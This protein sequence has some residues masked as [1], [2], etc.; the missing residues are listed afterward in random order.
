VV[1]C[2]VACRISLALRVPLDEYGWYPPPLIAAFGATA[3]VGR[4]LKLD[5]TQMIDAFSLTLNQTTCSAELKFSPHSHIRAVRDAFPAQI[6][7]TSALLARKG[8]RGF[9]HPFE[10]RA[11]FFALFARGEYTPDVLIQ[12]LG[13]VFAIDQI[14]FKPW[15]SCRGTHVFIEAAAQLVR[16]HRLDPDRIESIRLVGS[17]LNLMLAEPVAQKRRP[18]TAIDAK[19]S[20]P[21]TVATAL[22]RGAVTLDDFSAQ[23]LQ[24]PSV[25]E[26]AGL[27]QFEPDNSRGTSG[28]DVL[29]GSIELVMNSGERRRLEISDPAGSPQRPATEATLVAKFK[30]CCQRARSLPSAATIDKWVNEI[31]SL[32]SCADVGGLARSL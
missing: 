24:D 6:A 26:L 8:V 30:N 22:R 23:S 32:D 25:L 16:E 21:F 18:A 11:G 9:D 5:E 17:R 19:F 3:A 31:L 15:P 14:A 1:G 20:L 4:L 28:R 13:D 2:D 10:G 29:R 12:S 7:V 27:V